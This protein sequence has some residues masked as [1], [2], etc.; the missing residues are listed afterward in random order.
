MP[1]QK[2][3]KKMKKITFLI[4]IILGIITFSCSSENNENKNNEITIIGQWKLTSGSSDEGEYQ[5]NEC[6]LQNIIKFNNDLTGNTDEHSDDT[7]NCLNSINNFTYE[8]NNIEIVF[9]NTQDNE[10]TTATYSATETTFT[11]TINGTNNTF[12]TLNW[13]KI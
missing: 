9:H 8:I 11:Y 10:T 6:S 3:T 1:K 2:K 7:G 13:I 4:A 5:L 12:D